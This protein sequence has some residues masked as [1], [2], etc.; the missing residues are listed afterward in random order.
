MNGE[1]IVC[2]PE[3]VGRIGLDEPFQF[4]D[5]EN[6]IATAMRLPENLM[7]A[8]ATLVWAAARGDQ[9]NRTLAVSVAPGLYVARDVNRIACWP[10]LRIEIF[11]LCSRS[12]SD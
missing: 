7:A 6:R 8:P 2:H 11:D 12:G 4:I 1:H 3:H 9:R 5:D 10:W